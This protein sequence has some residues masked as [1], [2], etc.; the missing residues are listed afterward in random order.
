M[1]CQRKIQP[2]PTGLTESLWWR[3]L[4]RQ[5]SLERSMRTVRGCRVE[6]SVEPIRRTAVERE[7]AQSFE[8]LLTPIF[9]E[10]RVN[11]QNPVRSRKTLSKPGQIF[12]IVAPATKIVN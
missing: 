1:N 7:F 3:V 9:I 6:S 11:H 5:P 8:F 10:T 12:W 2:L 4:V